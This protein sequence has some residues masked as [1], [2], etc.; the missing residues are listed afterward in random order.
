MSFFKKG[1]EFFDKLAQKSE[2]AD[3]YWAAINK[4]LDMNLKQVEEFNK[5]E[6]I[7]S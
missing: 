3:K 6:T 7:S 2:N 5:E 1:A 4:V